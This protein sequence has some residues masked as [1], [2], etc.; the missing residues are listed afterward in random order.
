ML[1]NI[2]YLQISSSVENWVNRPRLQ[3]WMVGHKKM[4]KVLISKIFQ[5]DNMLTH[6]FY[7]VRTLY[8]LYY[9]SQYISV[10]YSIAICCA[11]THTGVYP[12]CRRK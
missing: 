8:Y 2:I 3:L 7:L 6:D 11:G 4:Y 1:C 5:A 10:S 9:E 12:N